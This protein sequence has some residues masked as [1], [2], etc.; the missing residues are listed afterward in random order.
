MQT[1]TSHRF[2]LRFSA[3]DHDQNPLSVGSEIN[4]LILAY[5]HQ[6]QPPSL[7]PRRTKMKA[8]LRLLTCLAFTFGV[9]LSAQSTQTFNFAV[10]TSCGVYSVNNTCSL[11]IITPSGNNGLFYEPRWNNNFAYLYFAPGDGTLDLGYAT[12]DSVTTTLISTANNGKAPNTQG[13]IGT[14]KYSEKT[15]FHQQS[16]NPVIFTG[17]T[18]IQYTTTT[19]CC[20]SGRGPSQHSVWTITGGTVKVTQ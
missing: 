5:G 2:E 17:S 8:A 7:N 18:A 19:Q 12:V 1:L 13:Y 20:S 4:A 10:P 6:P 14:A 16:G 3:L 9:V 11:Q 15:T